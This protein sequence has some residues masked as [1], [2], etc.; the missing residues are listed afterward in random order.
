[1]Q[2]IWKDIEG[3]EGIY[4]VSN[5]GRVRSLD[6]IRNGRNQYGAEFKVIHK[7]K[8]LTPFSTLTGY[9]EVSLYIKQKRHNFLIHRLVAQAFIP[10]IKE[11][12]EV[13][14][15]DGNKSNNRSDNL[16]WCTNIENQQHAI[17]TGLRKV[18]KVCQYSLNKELIKVWNNQYEAS[19]KMSIAQESINRCCNQ[20]VKTAG[21]YIWRYKEE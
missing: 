15:I 1:M 17:R 8:E 12:S 11:L 9:L 20:K 4:Q 10:N 18:K 6:R 2:E 7:G 21:G 16:E 5:L 3:Y 13:N 14:H 19:R